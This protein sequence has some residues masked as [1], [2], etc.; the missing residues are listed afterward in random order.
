MKQ[1]AENKCN[2]PKKKTKRNKKSLEEV[3]SNTKDTK[4]EYWPT[5]KTIYSDH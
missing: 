3:A 1:Y 4:R 5:R 2:P